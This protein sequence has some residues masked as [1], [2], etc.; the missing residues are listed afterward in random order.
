MDQ[1][2][3]DAIPNQ[4]EDMQAEIHHLLPWLIHHGMDDPQGLLRFA[5]PDPSD[6]IQGQLT[7]KSAAETKDLAVPEDSM[8]IRDVIN[9]FY[10]ITR[11]RVLTHHPKFFSFIPST[12]LPISWLADIVVSAANPH[13]GGRLAGSSCNLV[14]ENL[15]TWFIT[16]IGFPVDDAVGL[17]VSGGSMANF[18]ALTAA[19]D[20]HIRGVE[21]HSRAVIYVS[22]HTHFS[23]SKTARVLGFSPDQVREIPGLQPDVLAYVIRNDKKAG[24]V[25]MAVV[26]TLGST[27]SGKIDPIPEVAEVSREHNI[28]LHIDG[29]YGSSIILS[30]SHHELARG[31][32]KANSVTWDAHKWLFSS[33]GC[34]MLFVRNKTSL[35]RSFSAHSD[36]LDGSGREAEAEFW[37]LGLELT[38]PARAI[39]LW[40]ILRVLGSHQIGRMIDRG[41]DMAKEFETRFRSLKDWSVLSPAQMAILIVRFQPEGK[42]ETDIDGLNQRIADDALEKNIAAVQI[43]RFDGHSCLRMCVINPRLASTDPE[44]IV[45]AMAD[46]AIDSLS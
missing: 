41:I 28:W 3:K 19:R 25:P 7:S 23:I 46:I 14:E 22:E 27:V 38:R 33:Y 44:S 29:A 24:L 31:I 20:E 45:N 21:N 11:S 12:M 16:K 18:M 8:P 13:L 15:M 37:D 1:N 6:P 42:D 40:F 4:I 17:S 32:E 39:R 2:T 10:S 36:F 34:G 35:M 9:E 5:C 26:T 30:P 43:V